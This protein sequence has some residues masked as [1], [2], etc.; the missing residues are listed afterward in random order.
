VYCALD[1]S[2][3]QE[4]TT[5]PSAA[6]FILAVCRQVRVKGVDVLLNAFASIQHLV[7]DVTLM[8]LGDGPLLAEHQA[9]AERLGI[10]HRVVFRGEVTHPKIGEFFARAAMFVLPSRSEG[11]SMTLLEAAF[12]GKPIVCTRVGGSPELIANGINGLLV[13]PDDAAALGEAMLALLRDPDLAHRLARAAHETVRSRFLWKDCIHHYISIYEGGTGP[14]A[15]AG[16]P[17]PDQQH[18]IPPPVLGEPPA[19]SAR[20]YS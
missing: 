17:A 4:V 14:N 5:T 3:H 10:A 13:P 11:F 16:L 12:H 1:E 6:P 15:L 20:Q 7:P 18:A 8:V 9:L 19:D 2:R